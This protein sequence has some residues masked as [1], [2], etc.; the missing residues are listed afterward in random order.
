MQKCQIELLAE[1]RRL[2]ESDRDVYDAQ[3]ERDNLKAQLVKLRMEI[4]RL[5]LKCGEEG[6]KSLM[7]E[8]EISFCCSSRSF[9]KCCFSAGQA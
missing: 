7:Q 4:T 6:E 9:L 1:S 8:T 3:I 2:I 5:K